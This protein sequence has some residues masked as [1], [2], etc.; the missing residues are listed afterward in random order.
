[1][2]NKL[3]SKLFFPFMVCAFINNINLSFLISFKITYKAILMKTG[4]QNIN[5][6]KM[7]FHDTKIF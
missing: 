3:T 7:Y 4:S 1:M 2:Q 5:F 6:I